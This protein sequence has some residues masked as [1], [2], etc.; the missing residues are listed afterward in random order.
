MLR[1]GLVKIVPGDHVCG[2]GR[3]VRNAARPV[4][5]RSQC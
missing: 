5:V 2:L 1:Y 3:D 4:Y